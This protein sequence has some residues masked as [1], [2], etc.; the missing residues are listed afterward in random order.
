METKEELLQRLGN[1]KS[2]SDFKF[3]C[4]VCGMECIRTVK[5]LRNSIRS[6]NGFFC[7]KQCYATYKRGGSSKFN[8]YQCSEC[9][10]DIIRQ[11]LEVKDRTKVFCS[12]SCAAKFNNSKRKLT[13]YTKLKI[14]TSLKIRI[15]QTV[16]TNYTIVYV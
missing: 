8:I 7:S 3:N 5:S 15:G 16:L 13:E 9:G 6:G 10:V 11:T 2:L 1:E 14:S 12:H 4:E